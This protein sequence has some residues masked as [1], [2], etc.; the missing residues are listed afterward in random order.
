MLKSNYLIL[1]F[2]YYILHDKYY[3]NNYIKHLRENYL[4]FILKFFFLKFV[5]EPYTH[6]RGRNFSCIV[7]MFKK[8]FK[9]KA[10][11]Q[12]HLVLYHGVHGVFT[13]D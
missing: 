11:S 3:T 10:L 4:I 1:F 2:Y 8:K 9:I 6:T 12:W 5:V 13:L 7:V